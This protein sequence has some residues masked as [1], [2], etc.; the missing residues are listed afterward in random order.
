MGIFSY[1][2]TKIKEKVVIVFDIGSS[3]VGGVVFNLGKDGVPKIIFTVREPITLEMTIDPEQFLALTIKSLDLVVKKIYR[4]NL[5]APERIFCTL[6]SPWHVSETR[7]IRLE[8]NEPFIFNTKLADNLIQKEIALFEEE[9]LVK[10]TNGEDR[11]KLIEFKNIKTM[12][13]GYEVAKPLNQKIKELEITIFISISSQKVLNK[14]EESICKHFFCKDVKFFSFLLA[15]FAVVRD[16]YSQ[17]ENF[18]LIDI[19]GEVADISM[20]KKNAL[21]ESI[22][23]PLGV[24]F[25]IR[26][27]ASSMGS[28]IEEAK[29][30]ISLHKDG[31]ASPIEAKKIESSLNELRTKWLNKFQESLANISNDISIPATIYISIEKDLADFFCYAIKIEQFNQYSFTESKFE[32]VFLSPDVFHGMAQFAT[33]AVRESNFIIDSVYINR[34]LK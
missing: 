11:V 34:F 21:R 30:L 31:H 28:S 6:A 13:N 8:K 23:F 10:Y 18:L 1:F 14:I 5:G 25:I 19:G 33:N 26:G 15:S 12:L 27:V 22:S 17:T 20:V 29:S 24:N 4:Q 3:S 16:V 32:I 9:Y 2:K 7:T